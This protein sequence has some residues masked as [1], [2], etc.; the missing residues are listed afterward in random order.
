MF[1][2]L[3]QKITSDNLHKIKKQHARTL[4]LMNDK[5]DKGEV[6][7]EER[8]GD[9]CSLDDLEVEM[10]EREQYLR[11]MAEME[12]EESFL[13]KNSTTPPM[14]LRKLQNEIELLKER[15]QVEQMVHEREVEYQGELN[16]RREE[17]MQVELSKFKFMV[18]K[19]KSEESEVKQLKRDL[20]KSQ[21]I[22]EQLLSKI[23]NLET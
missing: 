4:H 19:Y 1:E 2:E 15:L 16:Q 11:K 20:L 18:D 13:R 17:W 6:M 8:N 21:E 23:E 22:E 10:E 7:G 9:E 5:R 3:Q 14:L 12:S